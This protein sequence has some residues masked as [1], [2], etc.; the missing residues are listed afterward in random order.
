[1]EKISS[2]LI[3]LKARLQMELEDVDSINK[4]YNFK[5]SFIGKGSELNLLNNRIKNLESE[6]KNS[7][8]SALQDIRSYIFTQIEK[9]KKDIEDAQIAKELI[10]QAVDITLPSRKVTGGNLHPLMSAISL[11]KS[12][13]ASIGFNF[14]E[15]P[16]IE[17]NWHN[18]TA[19]NIP[20]DHPARNLHDTFYIKG[21]DRLLRTHTSSVQIHHMQ[22]H[23]PPLKVISVGRVY[24]S[25]FDSTHTPMFHQLEGLAIGKS[26]SFANMKWCL[27]QFLKA[28]FGR[29]IE[30]RLRSSYFPFT[31]PSVEIDVR[32]SDSKWLEIMGCGMVHPNVLKNVNIDSTEYSG[33]AFGF[34]IERLA[35]I[36]NGIPDI[37]HLFS[38]DSCWQKAYGSVQP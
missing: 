19:L 36:K 15:G 2:L 3:D 13:F 26:I 22:N 10:Q 8:F 28:F 4:L 25:D 1:M 12:I 7:L 5:S 31:E 20:E 11:I 29:D 37:R 38:G 6:N 24:R 9:K 30:S 21:A 35:M 27:N 33:F 32:I 34:G 16:E 23:K 17:D 18:F 14:I